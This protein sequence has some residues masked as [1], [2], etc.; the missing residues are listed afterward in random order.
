VVESTIDSTRCRNAATHA[1]LIMA[2][3]VCWKVATPHAAR[4]RSTMTTFSDVVDL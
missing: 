1:E 4:R 3:M 2:V